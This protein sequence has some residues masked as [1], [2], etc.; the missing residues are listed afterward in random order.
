[1]RGLDDLKFGTPMQTMVQVLHNFTK[2]FSGFRVNEMVNNCLVFAICY[3]S[4][5]KK[6]LL[7]REMD[8]PGNSCHERF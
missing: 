1:M 8:D 6:L 2:Y 7:N 3:L 4:I 5:H